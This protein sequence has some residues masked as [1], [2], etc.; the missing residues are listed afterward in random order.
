MKPG[1]EESLFTRN[2][3]DIEAYLA[4][5]RFS[6]LPLQGTEFDPRWLQALWMA[7][8]KVSEEADEQSWT[9]HPYTAAERLINI[10]DY[11][12]KV[13]LPYPID[14]VLAKLADHGP[15]ICRRLEYFG[16]FNTSNHLA[17]NGRGL[18]RLGLSLGLDKCTEIGRRI[19]VEE[20]KRLFSPS[21]AL[22][23]GSS[24]YQ[25]LLGKNYLD[26]YLVAANFDLEEKTL[27]RDTVMKALSFWS[28]FNLP[29]GMPLVGDISPDCPPEFLT[30]LFGRMSG[31]MKCLPADKQKLATELIRS[32]KGYEK[33]AEPCDGWLRADYFSWSGLW[34]SSPHGWSHIPGHGHQDGGGFEL[35]YDADRIF[36][37]IGRGS[38][39]DTAGG[40]YQ[41]S[42]GAHNS[43]SVD[44]QNPYPPNKPYYSEEF[45]NHFAG[46][47]PELRPVENGIVHRHF[48]NRRFSQVENISRYWT[49]SSNELELV[50]RVKGEGTHTIERNL[51]TPL[52]IEHDGNSIILFGVKNKYRLTWS[53]SKIQQTDEQYWIAYGTPLSG[54]RISFLEHV[55]IPHESWLRLEVLT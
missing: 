19:L 26:V 4:V 43:V 51:H 45:R 7:W 55:S 48:G 52:R 3:E 34:H 23:E 42:V 29:G 10:L 37:D 32:L 11:G 38:Y 28:L 47:P 30:S 18:Y 2:F 50:D 12:E 40:R 6:W 16:E 46:P 27:F 36:I 15:K 49:F 44:G 21:G 53:D 41:T 22:R 1:E 24:H 9:W 33:Q 25:L 39:E 35:N 5:Q 54:T 17:N 13:G 14:D 20:Q 31:W 8:I